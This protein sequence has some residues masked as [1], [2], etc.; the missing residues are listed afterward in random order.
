MATEPH[1]A[2]PRALNPCLPALF[3][4]SADNVY[5]DGLKGNWDMTGTLLGKPVK[6]RAQGER[7]PAWSQQER[8]TA[9]RW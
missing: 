9:K 7:V 4:S 3:F 5:L 8:A 2:N 6:Y 1:C